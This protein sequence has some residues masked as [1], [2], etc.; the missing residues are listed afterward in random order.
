MKI[1]IVG[2]GAREHIIAERLLKSRH[3]PELYIFGKAN[4]PAIAKMAAG[5]HIGNLNDAVEV[6]TYAKQ[7]EVDFAV[8]GPED[9][10]ANG[11]VDA[12]DHI[13]IPSV[14][15]TKQL[16]QLESSKAFT[17]DLL[18]KYNIKGNPKYNSFNNIEAARDFIE[19][20]IQGP[21]VVKDDQLCGGKG[22]QV[23]GDHFDTLD[24]GLDF[25]KS[26]IDKSGS[27]VI[28][29]KLIGPEF[30]LISFA[31]GKTVVDMPTVQDHKRAYEGDTGPNT[32]GMGSYSYPDILPFLKAEDVEAAHAITV[33]TMKALEAE[34]GQPY[35][36]IMYGGFMLT[37][38]GVRLIEYNARFGD[39][40]AMN[41]LSLLETDF[42][43]IC[44]AIINQTLSE[45]TVEFQKKATVCKY[46][47]PEGYPTNSVKNVP[48][49]V[50][51]SYETS[52]KLYYASV[53]QKDGQ[54]LLGGSRAIACV[55]LADTVEEAEK[56]AEDAIQ[57]A[58]SGP[59]FHRKDIGTAEL[60]QQ[61][62][63]QVRSF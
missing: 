36:G 45:M 27:V 11:V 44:L 29:E 8:I 58:A 20:E 59:L 14:G 7:S 25:A 26:C 60:I 63:D 48:I 40:E 6:S 53:D 31:D 30:S 49:S 3:Q 62:I 24:Q 13:G 18:K 46:L 9:P 38:N 12:L 57:N 39:P 34:L 5:Y 23:Q 15:P 54:L 21:F 37:P 1:L 22:V 52:A 32:G 47:V 42:V 33:E 50:D 56:I 43:D 61:R 2:N 19:N 17:R 4:N 28:E 16:A 35:K 10:L 51:E 55:A 41:L